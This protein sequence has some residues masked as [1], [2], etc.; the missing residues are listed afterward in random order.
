MTCPYAR[1]CVASAPI[2]INN[3][4]LD[5][6]SFQQ[7]GKGSLNGKRLSGIGWDSSGDQ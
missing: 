1:Y 4:F 3:R 5:L 7:P 6:A 2:K